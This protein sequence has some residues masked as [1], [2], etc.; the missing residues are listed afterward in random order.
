[1]V[2]RPFFFSFLGPH[3][4]H[5]EVSR[6]GVQSE[7]QLPDYATA[8]AMQDP[9]RICDLHHSSQQ[10]WILNPL[11]KARDRTCILRATSWFHYHRAT[12]GTPTG[13][14][15]KLM[16]NE[17]F[18]PSSRMYFP[19]HTNVFLSFLSIPAPLCL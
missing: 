9:S 13:L 7:L 10:R 14:F 17:G 6:L 4:R 2:Y 8:T 11:N 3:L 19:P 5:T 1:M 16:K 18:P 12:I 15:E